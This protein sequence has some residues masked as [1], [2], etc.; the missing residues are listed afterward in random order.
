MRLLAITL[1]ALG[2]L[3]GT[4]DTPWA[5]T[6]RPDALSE[7]RLAQEFGA[8]RLLLK[9]LL[10]ERPA[11]GEKYAILVAESLSLSR[12]GVTPRPRLTFGIAPVVEYDHNI[13]GGFP[14][15]EISIGPFTFVV[16]PESRARSGL[17]FGLR[18][19]AGASLAV[20]DGLLFTLSAYGTARHSF[21]H[22]LNVLKYSTTAC[23]KYTSRTWSYVD[24]CA[25]EYNLRRDLSEEER[26]FRSVT[27]G[28]VF[29]TG[30][31]SHDVAVTALHQRYLGDSQRRLRLSVSSVVREVGAF[32][33]GVSVGDGP[34]GVLAMTQG[35][36]V[37][38]GSVLWGQ[39][40][41]VSLA[42]LREEGGVFF[43]Q[44]RSDERW[45]LRAN[46]RLSPSVDGYVSL[47][48]K[49]SSLEAFTESLFNIG[50]EIRGRRW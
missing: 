48:R 43:G 29:S 40:T 33:F 23:L 12:Q 32:D 41:R 10:K 13:N 22:D 24:A 38:F 5:R 39:P 28:R 16:D 15:D 35:V 4:P 9:T 30:N 36:D 27:F 8:A 1:L 3:L 20:A 34:D 18:A 21:E 26:F 46:R 14:V 42:Y 47:E 49:N 50:F 19:D 17:T 7:W 31:A 44:D 45:L 25:S 37:G 6:T 2:I 11:G